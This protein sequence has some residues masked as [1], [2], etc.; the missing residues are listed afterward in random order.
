MA[1]A[2][3]LAPVVLRP[4]DE[5]SP[6]REGGHEGDGEPVAGGLAQAGL[7]LDVVGHVREG[8][9]LGG[10]ALVGNRLVAAGK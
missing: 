10:A 9:A 3:E 7:V 8:V 2:G 5:V 4:V 6:V 1:A